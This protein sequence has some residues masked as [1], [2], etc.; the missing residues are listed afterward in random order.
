MLR[1]LP[2]IAHVDDGAGKPAAIQTH[3]GR[4]PII[5]FG[6]SDGAF[7]MLEYTQAGRGPRLAVII[8]HTDSAREYAHDR[9]SSIGR[10]DKTLDAAQSRGW[11]IVD[12]KRD[13]RR[14]FAFEK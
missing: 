10:L 12:M 5:A 2:E 4:R 11:T 13:W 14:V 3:I 6:N 1:K 7:E 8:R 9:K